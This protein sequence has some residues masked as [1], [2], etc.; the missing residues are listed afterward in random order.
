MKLLKITIASVVTLGLLAPCGWAADFGWVKDFNLCAEADP[1]DFRA[2]LEGRFKIGD[3]EIDAV[4]DTAETPADGYILL[5]MGEMSEQPIDEVIEAYE[6]RKGKGWGRLAK[7]LGIKP[8]SKAFHE[9]KRSQDLYD[10]TG[11]G[12]NKGK[13][14][15]KG[16][17][18][19]KS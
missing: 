7:S 3:L 15:F 14:K 6:V 19:I 18:K 12:K 10:D 13:A 2:R 5:R 4:F 8:G 17:K 9:L 16:K 1:S 11:R